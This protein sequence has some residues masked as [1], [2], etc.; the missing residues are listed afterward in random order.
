[1]NMTPEDWADCGQGATI[2]FLLWHYIS[3]FKKGIPLPTTKFG[4]RRP[5]KSDFPAVL[6]PGM[7]NMG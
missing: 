4:P 7:L 1:M 2:D 6:N 3:I 5:K